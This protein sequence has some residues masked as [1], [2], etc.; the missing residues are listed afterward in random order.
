MPEP[1]AAVLEIGHE[2]G[3]RYRLV[4]RIARGGMAEVWEAEDT[5]L[6]RPV[7]VKVLLPHLAADE[8]FLT[9]FRR[10]AVAAARLSHPH[11]VAIYDTCAAGSCEAIVMELVRGQ[12]LR[13]V[14]DSGT[15]VPVARAVD[16]GVQVADALSHAHAAGLVHR[17][18]KPGNI[19]LADDGR[20][21]VADFGI[22]KAAEAAADLTEVGQVVGTAKYLAPEQ[23]RSE[24]VDG[25]SDIYS[26]GIVLYELLCGRPPFTGTDSTTTALARLTT[27]PLRPRQVRA[28]IQRSVEDVVMRA[29]AREPDDRYQSAAE[30]RDALSSLLLTTD[31]T[32]NIVVADATP[33][34][35]PMPTT[36]ASSERS[37]MVPA[38]LI[39]V[40]AL[41]LGVIGVLV[42][43]TEVGRD[44]IE[45]VTGGGGDDDVREPLAYTART[46]DPQGDGEENPDLLGLLVDG[47]PRSVWRTDQYRS[48]EWGGLKD[49][50]GLLLALD[51]TH[52]VDEL[53][54]ESPTPG[55]SGQVFVST[56][57]DP[58]PTGDPVATIG[59]DD[60]SA[61]LGGAEARVVLLWITDPGEGNRFEAGEI[62][63]TG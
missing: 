24:E 18:V 1:D 27:E 5:V 6:A 62:R 37:W 22:A 43:G 7:A 46:F 13:D 20:V 40:V 38:A 59:A 17:D 50:V 44:L 53:V 47:D 58:Q 36:F 31:T 4:S 3:G 11:I 32:G 8:A 9:R 54:V 35:A 60:A 10:E 41:T 39:L 63:L 49:G 57:G 16:I 45:N 51:G 21:L 25:R 61:D 23:V 33:V 55:W 15:P 52:A 29:M 42:G 14:L 12:T 19:L 2:I 34:P 30:L 48:R 26:L 28:G 56:E